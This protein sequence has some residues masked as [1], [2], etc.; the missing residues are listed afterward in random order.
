MRTFS[1]RRSYHFHQ[2]CMEDGIPQQAH[3]LFHRRLE[4]SHHCIPP[5]IVLHFRSSGMLVSANQE[6]MHR[7]PPLPFLFS[8]FF[9]HPPLLQSTESFLLDN[10]SIAA[11]TVVNE[12]RSA[13]S[14]TGSTRTFSVAKTPLLSYRYRPSGRTSE[15]TGTSICSTC[16]ACRRH[17]CFEF[18]P[19]LLH[20]KTQSSIFTLAFVTRKSQWQVLE[21]KL[22]ERG[23]SLR[24]LTLL[25]AYF[26]CPREIFD[27]YM[28]QSLGE[29][30]RLRS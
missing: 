14:K 8:F 4:F 13:T 18:F 11:Q 27:R 26:V 30:S 21:G 6:N 3:E 10:L 28:P 9:F 2:T 24:S 15:A 16:A 22:E 1:G 20:H 25:D 23:N 7:T 17:F 29:I 5:R 12:L 19:F